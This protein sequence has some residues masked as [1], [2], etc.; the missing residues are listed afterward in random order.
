MQ[1]AIPEVSVARLES[2]SK[3]KHVHK[4]TGVYG[5]DDG[6]VTGIQTN[7]RTASIKARTC[8]INARALDDAV[9]LSFSPQR[10]SVCRATAKRMTVSLGNRMFHAL[11]W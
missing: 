1:D 4:L 7:V 3:A 11:V 8:R 9:S 2:R 10:L 5:R 6:A